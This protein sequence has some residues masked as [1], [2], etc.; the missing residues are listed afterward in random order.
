MP[1]AGVWAVAAGV[2]NVIP[3]LGPTAIALSAAVVGFLHFGTIDKAIIVGLTCTGIASAE[4][5]VITPVLMG[6]AGRMNGAAVFIALTIWGF[7]WGIW[8]LLLAVPLTM[9]IKVL[10]DHVEELH[11]VGELL[12]E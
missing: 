5:F 3:Y 7:L 8:G 1:A 11:G 10:C 4:G 2:L 12:G 6:R 9:A